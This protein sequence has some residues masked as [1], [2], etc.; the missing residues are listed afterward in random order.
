MLFMNVYTCRKDLIKFSVVAA[1]EKGGR[2][3]KLG[4]GMSDFICSV[5][6]HNTHI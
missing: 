1:S 4:R 3:K 5:L 6:I 2:G